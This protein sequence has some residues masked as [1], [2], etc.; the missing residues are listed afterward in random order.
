MVDAARIELE[1][2]L[3]E[4]LPEAERSGARIRERPRSRELAADEIT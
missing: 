1:R 3:L 4:R 2:L